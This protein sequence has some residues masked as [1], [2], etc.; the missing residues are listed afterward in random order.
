[1]SKE[2]RQI[3]RIANTDL[4][5]TKKIIYALQGIKGIGNSLANVMVKM[6]DL[7]P[8]DRLGS[9]SDGKIEKIV[10]FIENP[11]NYGLPEW[12]L[13]RPR[14]NETGNNRHLFGSNLTLQTK[15]DIDQMKK[16]RSWRG[17]R[18]AYGLKVR[19]Q[20][21]KTTGRRKR[22]SGIKKRRRSQ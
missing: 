16:T 5:G 17:T 15:S 18:H 3:V 13:N 9:L 1:M 7:N 11:T 10:D 6:G 14:C 22:S 21:T 19:G 8:E 2:F 20:R 4:D 12:F